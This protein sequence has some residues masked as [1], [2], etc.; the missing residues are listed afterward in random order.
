MEDKKVIIGCQI[1][2]AIKHQF[3]LKAQK[4]GGTSFVLREL[5]NGFSED[6]VFIKAPVVTNNLYATQDEFMK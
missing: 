1:D 2:L 3:T 4:F 5:I 6:R